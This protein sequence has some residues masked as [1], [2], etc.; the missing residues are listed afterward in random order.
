MKKI[1]LL[2][3]LVLGLTAFIVGC[4]GANNGDDENTVVVSGKKFTEQVILAN[5]ISQLLTDRTDLNVVNKRDLGPTDV[6]QQGLIDGDIDIYAEYTGTAYMIIMKEELDTT[7]PEVI[8]DRVKKYYEENFNITWLNSFGFNNTYALAVREEMANELGLETISDLV[9]HASKLT[10]GSDVDF[11]ERED[12]FTNFNKTYGIE[13]KDNRGMDPGLM[14][15]AVKEGNMDVITAYATDGRIPRFNLKLL[16]DDK[17]FFPPYYAA[18]IIRNEV[19][20]KHPEIADI[21][22][23]LVPYLTNEKM[24]ELNSKVDID[25]VSDEK[26]AKDFL[27]EIGLIS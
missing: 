15:T 14:Y 1:S 19:L 22:N 17:K 3:V 24:A 25:G 20:E 26:V 18:P 13:W 5:I 8:Y 7:D 4:S 27:I 2:L 6:L 21:L 12:G 10:L 16:E 9:P 11:L 23:E